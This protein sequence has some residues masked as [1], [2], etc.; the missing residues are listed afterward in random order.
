MP[1][2]IA[3]RRSTPISQRIGVEET[4]HARR[5]QLADIG[6]SDDRSQPL[7]AVEEEFVVGIGLIEADVAVGVDETGHDGQPGGVKARQI[8]RKT[9][10]RRGTDRQNALTRQQHIGALR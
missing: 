7:A 9:G 5:E 8:R 4:G 3:S 2:S 1:A 6:G 10:A